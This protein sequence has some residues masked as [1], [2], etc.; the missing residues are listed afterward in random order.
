MKTWCQVCVGRFGTSVDLLKN[1]SEFVAYLNNC[2][3]YVNTKAEY[4]N[5]HSSVNFDQ[6][7][8]FTESIEHK[9][10]FLLLK[11]TNVAVEILYMYFIS[12][13]C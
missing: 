3:Y 4:I 7:T 6:P 11:I 9:L 13:G 2:E 12:Q 8:N 10:I 5:V 1:I